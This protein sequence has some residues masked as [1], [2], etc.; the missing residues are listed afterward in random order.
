MLNAIKVFFGGD[1]RNLDNAID[2]AQ[3]KVGGFGNALRSVVAGFSFGILVSQFNKVRTELDA[4]GKTA[5]QIGITTKALQ[6]LQFGAMNTGVSVDALRTSLVALNRRAAVAAAGGSYKKA[7]EDIGIALTDSSG[8]MRST[9]ELLGD[10]A[11]A[12]QNATS[13]S[14]RLRIADE[15]M[16]ET[17][18]R[19]VLMLQDGKEGLDEFAKAAEAAGVIIDDKTIRRVEELNTRLDIFKKRAT[20][21]G[22][23]ALSVFMAIGEAIGTMV[24]KVIY[25]FD[26]F[27]ERTHTLLSFIMPIPTLIYETVQAFYRGKDE[28][29]E[30][31]KN[32]NAAAVAVEEQKKAAERAL[33]V[34]QERV[35]VADEFIKT[36]QAGLQKVEELERQR[37]MASA[38]NLE[39]E[40]RLREEMASIAQQQREYGDEKTELNARI[41][42]MEKSMELEALQKA[43]AQELQN[44]ARRLSD[45]RRKNAMAAMAD[46]QRLIKLQEELLALQKEMDT[47]GAD[48]P[49]VERYKALTKIEEKLGEIQQLERQIDAA[50]KAANEKQ[51]A[52]NARIQEQIDAQN[53]SRLDG[54]KAYEGALRDMQ[55]GERDRSARSLQEIADRVDPSISYGDTVKARR[56]QR[57]EQRARELQDR[58]RFE[59]AE[60]MRSRGDNLR[61]QLTNLQSSERDP[62]A[63]F[64]KALEGTETNVREINEKLSILE[65]QLK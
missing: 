43:M 11:N 35:K 34:E 41:Q 52:D 16:S 9:E 36:Y 18:R 4:I 49:E 30:L 47:G 27:A 56:I 19:L 58:G 62:S 13:Q 55:T 5:D 15:L 8:A 65:G 6:E 42:L 39:K 21:F 54:I 46:D 57:Y 24:G 20:A 38:T 17:G 59:A 64:K 26:T 32:A 31:T 63:P 37:F 28:V 45:A 48:L 3:K 44:E 12:I 61:K 53:K 2:G 14:E 33:K 23:T 51:K 7:F 22:A 40:Q 25:E 1:T 60:E 29:K 50:K 10:V